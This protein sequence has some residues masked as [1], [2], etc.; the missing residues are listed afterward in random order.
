[1]GIKQLFNDNLRK[2]PNEYGDVSVMKT[3]KV[4]GKSIFFFFFYFKPILTVTE[5]GS[6]KIDPLFLF[7]FVSDIFHTR[8][9]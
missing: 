5:I 4:S 7:N 8:D 3:G 6:F 2:V 1:M 9:C